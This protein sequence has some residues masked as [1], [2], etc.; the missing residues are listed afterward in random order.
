MQYTVRNVPDVIDEA[1]RERA[2][3][4]KQSLNRVLI[5]ALAR[6]LGLARPIS[7]QRDLS[8]VAGSW[9]EDAGTEAALEDQGRIDPE[10]WQ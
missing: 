3:A 4:D 10:L 1:I 2:S 5:D 8:D 9:V 6:G 7:K